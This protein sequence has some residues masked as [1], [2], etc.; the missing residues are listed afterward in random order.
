MDDEEIQYAQEH[1]PRWGLVGGWAD[2]VEDAVE[3]VSDEYERDPGRIHDALEQGVMP[4]DVE[5]ESYEPYD[6][7][8]VDAYP[9]ADADTSG[10]TDWD[11]NQQ[12]VDESANPWGTEEGGY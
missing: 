11:Y 12:V 3:R 8:G 9:A 10:G 5:R 7:Q 2:Q 4:A 6:P 1:D